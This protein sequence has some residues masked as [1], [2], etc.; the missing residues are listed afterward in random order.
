MGY[1]G[2]YE[3]TANELVKRITALIPKHPEILKLENAW[4]LFKV[5]GFKC[6]DLGPS[7]GQAQ[8]ALAKAIQQ[9]EVKK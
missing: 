9:W 2:A 7:L 1:E 5:E 3:W 4:G 8:F 6:D